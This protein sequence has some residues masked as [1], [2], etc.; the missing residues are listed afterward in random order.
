MSARKTQTGR[1]PARN[2][3]RSRVQQGARHRG[4][5]FEGM[6]SDARSPS[7]PVTDLERYMA[8]FLA[9][10][11]RSGWNTAAVLHTALDL[12]D[13]AL[14]AQDFMAVPAAPSRHTGHAQF[15]RE[16]E[17]LTRTYLKGRQAQGL[18]AATLLAERRTL[19]RFV[20][21]ARKAGLRRSEPLPP[22]STMRDEQS[23]IVDGARSRS[24]LKGGWHGTGST[25]GAKGGRTK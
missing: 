5:D 16:M 24:P 10:R 7:P 14:F 4:S 17:G 12:S 2:A 1:G 13:F 11:A 25:R 3:A 6:R 20:R 15:M 18:K 19:A 8:A 22:P 23:T 9:E 21:L